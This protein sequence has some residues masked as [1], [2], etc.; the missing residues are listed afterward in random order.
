MAERESITF[1]TGLTPPKIIVAFDDET[2]TEYEEADAGQYLIDWPDRAADLVAMGW[3][4]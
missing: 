1:G 2:T 4:D 3:S